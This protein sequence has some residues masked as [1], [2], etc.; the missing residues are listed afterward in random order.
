MA[1]IDDVRDRITTQ[2]NADIEALKHSADIIAAHDR[3]AQFSGLPAVVTVCYARTF[4]YLY[5]KDNAMDYIK[6]YNGAYFGMIAG[7]PAFLCDVN[8]DSVFILGE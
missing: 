2:Y 5:A 8:G 6:Q 4:V 3:A 7:K 1:L